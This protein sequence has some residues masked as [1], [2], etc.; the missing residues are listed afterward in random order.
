LKAKHYYVVGIY[1]KVVVYAFISL[2]QKLL[3]N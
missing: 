3:V 1:L 2:K